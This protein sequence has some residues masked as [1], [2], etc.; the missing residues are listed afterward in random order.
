MI[1]E[2]GGLIREYR[3]NKEVIEIGD[4]GSVASLWG[5]HIPRLDRI[6][7]DR[8]GPLVESLLPSEV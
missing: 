4:L 6:P 3:D 7:V 1:Y 8:L 5:H 2:K